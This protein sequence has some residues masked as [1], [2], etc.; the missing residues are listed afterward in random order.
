M[1]PLVLE[2]RTSLSLQRH[3]LDN[4]PL[5]MPSISSSTIRHSYQDSGLA[6]LIWGRLGLEI[7][8]CR[9]KMVS[10]Q[11]RCAFVNETS[12][13]RRQY[14]LQ[15]A[16]QSQTVVPIALRSHWRI[17]FTGEYFVSTL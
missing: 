6:S 1:S 2:S 5:V 17:W 12:R 3:G 9:Q 10:E 4:M 14:L 7:G 16:G 13:E 11:A 8:V 15:W